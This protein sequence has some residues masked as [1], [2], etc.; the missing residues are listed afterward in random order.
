MKKARSIKVN[1]LS[2]DQSN[3]HASWLSKRD[4]ESELPLELI[5]IDPLTVLSS[6]PEPAVVWEVPSISVRLLVVR[7]DVMAPS[8]KRE[9][10]PIS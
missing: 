5:P 4:D 9:L 8:V 3:V 6:T 10:D 7:V 1:S 2:V